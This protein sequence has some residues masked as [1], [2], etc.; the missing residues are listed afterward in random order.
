MNV[1]LCYIEW[2]HITVHNV[3]LHYTPSQYITLHLVALEQLHVHYRTMHYCIHIA[4][5]DSVGATGGHDRY[6]IFNI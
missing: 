3:I 6:C 2:H 1:T 5:F 4:G